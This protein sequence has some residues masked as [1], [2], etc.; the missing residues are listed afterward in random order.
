MIPLRD[1]IPA[2]SFPAATVLLITLNVLTF[3]YELSLG[4]ELDL[5]I[6]QNGAVPLRFMWAWQRED[7]STV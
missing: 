4:A 6:T 1:A 5:F 2:Q 3:V 7:V